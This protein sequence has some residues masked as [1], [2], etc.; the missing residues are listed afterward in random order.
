MKNTFFIIALLTASALFA[1]GGTPRYV[2]GASYFDPAAKGQ[3]IVW[4]Q[5]QITYFTD[6]GDLSPLLPHAAADAFVADSLSRWTSIPTA[7][8]V[9][10]QG[11]QLSED[12]NGTNV[13]ID[14]SGS[15]TLPADIQPGA[16]GTPVAVVY[17]SDGSVTDA[18]LGAGAGLAGNCFTNAVFG[19]VDNF[20]TDGHLAHALIVMNGNCVQSSTDLAE[21]Q[22]R[23]VRAF[24]QVLGLGWSQLNLNVITGKP[25]APTASDRAGFPVMHSIDPIS[26]VPVSRC[27]S[28]P[29]QPKED[30]RAA[31]SR[32]YPVTPQNSSSFP[33]KQVFADNTAR[34]H[35][36]VYFPDAAGRAAQGMQGVNVVARYVDPA[37]NQASRQYAASSISGFLFRGNAGNAVTGYFDAIGQPFDRFGSDDPAAQGFFDL[38][39][40]EIPNGAAS[41]TF[42]LTVE[43]LDPLWSQGVQPYGPWQVQPSGMSQT[44]R[45]TVNKGGDLQQDIVMNGGAT[46]AADAR[47]PESF[48]APAALP[49]G[50]DWTGTLSG[51]G[52]GDYFS[53]TGKANRTLSVDVT[54]LDAGGSPTQDKARPVV[55]IWS[56]SAAPDVLPGAATPTA[57]STTVFGLSRLDAQLLQST[58][59]RVGI[60]DERGDGRPDYSYHARV[61]YGDSVV[62]NRIPVG[63][64]IP[65][66]IAGMGFGAGINVTVGSGSAPILSRTSTQ[67]IAAVPSLADGLYSMTI[68]DPATGASSTMTDVLTFGAGPNDM[69]LLLQGSNPP[70]PAGTEAINP[71]RVRVVAPDGSTPVAGATVLLSSAPPVSFSAC[72]GAS[73]C[74]VLSDGTGE[75]TT[76]MTPPQSGTFSIIAT[77]APGSYPSPKV[78]QS[79]LS[80]SSTSL[81]IAFV[82]GYR[83]VAAG[84]SLDMPIAARVVSNGFA[85]PGK[86]VDF[87]ITAG[88]ALLTTGTSVTDSQGYATTTL[89]LRNLGSQVTLT[90]CVSP[91]ETPCATMNV[92]RVAT[93]NIQLEIVSGNEQLIPAGQTFQPIK[94]R[95][96]DSSTPSNPVEGAAVS[97]VGMILRPDFDV[98][99]GP[100]DDNDGGT[101]GMPVILGSWQALGISDSTGSAGLV[102]SPGTVTGPLEIEVVATAGASAI[103]LF[104]LESMDIATAVPGMTANASADSVKPR[105]SRRPRNSDRAHSSARPDF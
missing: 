19:G 80:A 42:E 12:V 60:A 36:S 94:V 68:S 91:A 104:E 51:Y 49:A 39:G 89:Q 34:V 37:T 70:T 56:L 83:L 92:Y 32:L 45:V 61:L 8:L 47:E 55:G 9:G 24:G 72:G 35:G 101:T 1:F 50:G 67:I 98:Y 58:S 21:V 43:A 85:L 14:A 25:Q 53:F 48:L 57:F 54:A 28:S 84:A 102:P 31:L 99:D 30:D 81:D 100:A 5:G 96:V 4:A 17:D 23:L 15:I 6:Q 63:G 75:I 88:S 27:Y 11:G 2:A 3:P 46:L 95:V 86:R 22:Y 77:L 10:T 40:L 69:L 82:N 65:A 76:R 66:I 29:D 71:F 18:L 78:V 44:I 103:Q 20:T 52:D 93:A 105:M 64:G 33:G 13:S 74:V 16:I 97:F 7:A 73:S 59:F 62:P 41:A 79:T 90:G 38:A 87:L 26:C